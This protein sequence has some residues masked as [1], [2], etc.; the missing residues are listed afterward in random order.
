MEEISEEEVMDM[1]VDMVEEVMD[2]V[3]EVMDIVEE[4]MAEE[5]VGDIGEEKEMVPKEGIK[6]FE[7]K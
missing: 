6:F 4:D 1:V 5:M 7:N 3:E 2:I